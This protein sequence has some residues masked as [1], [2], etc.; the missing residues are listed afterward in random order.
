MHHTIPCELVTIIVEQC[1][2]YIVILLK[3][4]VKPK[5]LLKN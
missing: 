2:N 4:Y 1:E 3:D 5:F